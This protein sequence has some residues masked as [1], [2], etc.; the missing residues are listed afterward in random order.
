MQALNWK[1]LTIQYKM[2]KRCCTR[3]SL[4]TC[5]TS[6]QYF[7]LLNLQPSFCR[8]RQTVWADTAMWNSSWSIR[9]SSRAE[10]PSCASIG[11]SMA[12]KCL[13]ES[14]VPLPFPLGSQKLLVAL[15]FASL[16]ATMASSSCIFRVIWHFHRENLSLL[17]AFSHKATVNPFREVANHYR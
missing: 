6:S 16:E 12:L 10:S 17:F 3:F 2:F 14:F 9:V 5:L 7:V 15:Y 11:S 8:T 4:F 13:M 1:I